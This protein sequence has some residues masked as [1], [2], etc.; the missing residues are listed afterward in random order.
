MAKNAASE[1]FLGT[2]HNS[3][4]IYLNSL[5]TKEG[6]PTAAELSVINSF[7]D[8]NDISCAVSSDNAVGRLKEQLK[9]V[10]APAEVSD[11]DKTDALAGVLDLAQYRSGGTR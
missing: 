11:K 6:G 7:L 4:A 10:G 2:L 9:G 1:D 8:K 5:L 3:F